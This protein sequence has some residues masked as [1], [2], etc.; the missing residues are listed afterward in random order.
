MV[1]AALFCK[2]VGVDVVNEIV[3]TAD[4][5]DLYRQIR[6]ADLNLAG[7]SF[8]DKSASLL[9]GSSLDVTRESSAFRHLLGLRRSLKV[10]VNYCSYFYVFIYTYSFLRLP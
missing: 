4:I 3:L 1:C 7:A 9:R 8:K 2:Q 5:T 10:C 6:K